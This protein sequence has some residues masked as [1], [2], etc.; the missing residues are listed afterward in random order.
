MRRKEL[1]R[2]CVIV[3]ETANAGLATACAAIKIADLYC[4]AEPKILEDSER[5]RLV[6]LSSLSIAAK[7]RKVQGITTQTLTSLSPETFDTLQLHELG[8]DIIKS[9]PGKLNPVTASD[10][11]QQLCRVALASRERSMI[12]GGMEYVLRREIVLLETMTLRPSVLAYRAGR[13]MLERFLHEKRSSQILFQWKNLLKLTDDEIG[14][15]ELFA[16]R[17]CTPLLAMKRETAKP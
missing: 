3:A 8:Q 4:A 10:L 11:L 6:F 9:L 13:R 12:F 1:S 15:R 14:S 7:E 17:H 16:D 2:W 5:F